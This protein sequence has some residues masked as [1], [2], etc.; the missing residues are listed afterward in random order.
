MEKKPSKN[1]FQK[2]NEFEFLNKYTQDS[3]IFSKLAHKL[4]KKISFG[5]SLTTNQY[6]N[7]S[8]IKRKLD[9]LEL[10]ESETSKPF[11]RSNTPISEYSSD[12]DLG[13][14]ANQPLI[15]NDAVSIQLHQ[16]RSDMATGDVSQVLIIYTGGTIGM[17][18]TKKHGYVPVPDYLTESLAEMS[19]FHDRTFDPNFRRFSSNLD[20]QTDEEIYP[21]IKITVKDLNKNEYVEINQR[22]LISPPSLVGKRIRYSII[23]YEP[24]LDSCNMSSDDWIRIASDIESNYE[25][26]DAFIILHGTDTMAYTASALSFLLE[27]LG[28]TVILTGS[29]VPISEVRNDAVENLL[30]ALTIAGHYVIPEVCLF[31]N[32]KLFRGNR[33]VKM[34][35]VDFDAFD[36]PNLAPLATVGININ[37]NWAEVVRP[38][39]IAKFKAHKT[40]NR[41][42]ST[43]RLFPGITETTVKALLVEP[44]EGVILETYGAGNAPNT[45]DDIMRALAAASDRGVVIVNC[46]Q[47]KKG[48]VTD[49]YATGKALRKVGVVSG[50]DMTPECALV[51]LAYLLSD[52]RYQPEVV[53]ELMTRN[54]RGELTI[55]AP[56]PRFTFHN[57]THKII[58]NMINAAAEANHAAVKDTS[59]MMDVQEKVLMEKSLY[60]ILLCSA[61]GTDDLD[62]MLLLSENYE[63]MMLMLNCM[64]Y[65]GRTPL[66]IAC[67]G[68][69]HRIVKFL[70]QNGASVHMRDRFGHTPL[71]EAARNKHKHVI[72]TLR[73][74]GAHF[75]DAEINDVVFQALSAAANGDVELLKHFVDAGLDINRTG[76]DHRTAL[77]HAVAEGC[78]DTVQYLLSLPDIN[79][80]TKDRWGRRPIDD[81]EMNLGR[82]WGRDNETEKQ[83]REIVRLLRGRVDYEEYGTIKIKNPLQSNEHNISNSNNPHHLNG[84]NGVVIVVNAESSK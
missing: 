45:R 40:L 83:L 5:K 43:L 74:T 52:N 32:N 84:V 69:H 35:A 14:S 39:S 70:L 73:E 61:A 30:G 16:P 57:R 26:F 9:N 2:D 77:H 62:G 48:I 54:L 64:D 66:H 80:E 41:N 51:K 15:Y 60:P 67:T 28:K 50:N 71:Y 65:D 27:D 31:F 55:V 44:I 23:E 68:G 53:R 13:P 58:Q 12:E 47:C 42:V 19:R 10:P 1:N 56:K 59:L 6:K 79:I 46:T 81:A 34:N 17:K 82:M 75:N 22:S 36:S 18:N 72:H 78:L 20:D 37:V 11:V 21:T 63:G 29:Q 25:T 4:T 3:Q 33:C 76:F 49:L 38:A 7:M 8:S 24:L